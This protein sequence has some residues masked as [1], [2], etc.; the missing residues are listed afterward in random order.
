MRRR[1][2]LVLSITLMVALLASGLS[3]IYISQ[4]LRQLITEANDTANQLTSQLLYVVNNAAPDLSSTKVDTNNLE[5]VNRDMAYYLGS[6]RD[7]NVILTTVVSSWPTVY[8]AAI[9]DSNGKAILHSNRDMVGKIVPAR[10]S[11]QLVQDARFRKQLRLIYR[12]P[13][14]YDV[15][16]PLMLGGTRFGSIRVG[17]STVFL[18]NEITPLLLN[19]A[20]YCSVAVLLALILAASLSRLAL[21]PL[22]QISKRL[23]SVSSGETV[24]PTTESE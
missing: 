11:L 13:M 8:D 17:I 1:T 23:D 20:V 2:K 4:I 21:G 14:V 5:A 10:P 18:K 16:T 12:T 7:L 24:A 22:E 19:A 15:Q 6:D 3:Y 9:L